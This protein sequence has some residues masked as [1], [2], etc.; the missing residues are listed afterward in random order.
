MAKWTHTD[1]GG[2]IFA[3]KDELIPLEEITQVR[4]GDSKTIDFMVTPDLAVTSGV[5]TDG[6][7]T[8]QNPTCIQLDSVSVT[9]DT[10]LSLAYQLPDCYD[11]KTMTEAEVKAT[12]SAK[13]AEE[14]RKAELLTIIDKIK[15]TANDNEGIQFS[16][17][18]QSM[19]SILNTLQQTGAHNENIVFIVS[20]SAMNSIK[21]AYLLGMYAPANGA[22]V[23]NGV[24][25]FRNDFLEGY[26]IKNIVVM[27]DEYLNGG[28][29]PENA[30]EAV[31]VIGF[32]YSKVFTNIF[33]RK[34]PAI[35]SIPISGVGY[36][37]QLLMKEMLG[38]TNVDIN[39]VCYAKG[40]IEGFDD[41]HA[42]DKH[43]VKKNAQ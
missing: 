29:L 24:V 20:N 12:L 15:K 18:S 38:T 1:F 22:A 36:V 10:Q 35:E 26:G 33:C 17:L 19:I 34:D 8:A 7:A 9:A 41:N 3:A 5:P 6:C 42:H 31:Q 25:D 23:Y 32:D 14:L 16:N 27:P 11:L 21:S 40:D 43:N 13:G 39:R 28:K 30:S 4:Y 37:D 2:V